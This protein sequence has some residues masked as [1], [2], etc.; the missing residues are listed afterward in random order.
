MW[1]GFRVG[2]RMKLYGRYIA[3]LAIVAALGLPLAVRGQTSQNMSINQ[4]QQLLGGNGLPTNQTVVSPQTTI[5]EP[6]GPQGQQVPRSRLEEIMSRR[7]GVELRQFGYDQLGVGRPVL[8]PQAGAL[9][10][11]YV[12]GPGDEIVVTLRGQENSEYRIAVNRDGQVVLPRLPP[13]PAAGR[14]LGDFRADVSA[15][16]RRAF[17][18]T[19]S[20]VTV[21]QLRQVSVSVTGEVN[22]PGVRVLTG[23]SS[24]VDAILISGGVKKTG[25]LR[26]VRVVRAGRVVT[27][28]LYGILTQHAATRDIALT[29]GDRIVVPS[30][31]PTVAVVGWVRR[32]GIY[33]LAA[34]QTGMPASS[35]IELAG[36]FEVRGKYRISVLRLQASGESSMISL[37]GKS[38]YVRDSE[39]LFALPA[40]QQTVNQA[41]LSG[42]SPLAGQYSLNRATRL[43][44]LLRSPGAMGSSPY[45][46]FGI[47]V[48]KDPSTLLRGLVAFT[49][50]SVINGRGDMDLQSDDT[51]RVLSVKEARLLFAIVKAF[52]ERRVAADEALRAPQ[53]AE[54][55][56]VSQQ[57]YAAAIRGTQTQ[58]GFTTP[59]GQTPL[60]QTTG[61]KGQTQQTLPRRIRPNDEREDIGELSTMVLGDTGLVPGPLFARDGTQFEQRSQFAPGQVAGSAPAMPQPQYADGSGNPAYAYN[62]NPYGEN[63]YNQAPNVLQQP[64]ATGYPQEYLP[65]QQPPQQDESTPF[66]LL[67][68]NMQRQSVGLSEVPTNRE[69]RTFGQLARQ[70][71]IDPLVLVHFLMDHEVTINGAVRGAGNYLVGPG[72][73]LGELVAAA[74]G[75]AQWADASGVQLITTQVDPSIGKASTQVLTLPLH[76]DTLASYIVQ[77]HDDLRFNQI[78][79]DAGI[80]SVTVQ[81]EVRHPGVYQ[82]VR[83]EHLS[84]LLQQVGGLTDVAYPYGAVYLRRSAAALEREGYQRA[85]QEIENSLLLATTRRDP[86]ARVQPEAFASMQTFVARLRNQAALGRITAT[87]DPS[88]LA[89]KPELDVLLEPGDVLYIPQRPNTVSVLGEVMQPGG[90][91]FTPSATPSDYIER[92]GSYSQFADEDLT[93]VILPDGTANKVEKSW[94]N[95]GNNRIPPGSAI[96]VPRDVSPLDLGLLITQITQIFSQLAVT[97]ASLAVV[98][99]HN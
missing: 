95:F 11:D 90:Y 25:S 42:G 75:T 73:N 28:D 84:D 67:P 40:A 39:I 46:L 7:A 19:D 96:V 57:Q 94:L 52:R 2:A 88:V 64:G 68:D 15:A 69:V 21:G 16:V 37:P 70:L 49:P 53:V 77:P 87:A 47:V 62:Q 20:F 26:N 29:D 92:A 34:G 31:G 43:S 91:T 13:I 22:S 71:D 54:E 9:Q 1:K 61:D 24:V 74:G 14:R 85:A 32:P 36:G 81:G 76:E 18:A 10:D 89:V 60:D 82:L 63:A 56:E 78:F 45:S 97:A 30:L 27:V 50:V 72:V 3:L 55:V 5:L 93:F 98:S 99:Q 59:G 65:G 66:E 35:L 83:G 44:D 33:E 17:V 12:L 4:L 41:V 48:R 6:V 58:G 79:N 8:L 80:G 23:L 51:V 38:G 86:N